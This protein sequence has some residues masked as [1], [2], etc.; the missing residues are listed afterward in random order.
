MDCVWYA[1][2][3]QAA[4]ISGTYVFCR[5]ARAAD[6]RE[7]PASAS[8]GTCSMKSL[9]A[10]DFAPGPAEATQALRGSVYVSCPQNRTLPLM[11]VQNA[12]S[13]SAD[14]TLGLYSAKFSSLDPI[15]SRKTAPITC[16]APG[17]PSYSPRMASRA[18]CRTEGSL[19][20]DEGNSLMAQV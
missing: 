9:I 6:A 10:A 19:R 8:R 1:G 13:V 15:P 4:L 11:A 12:E 2:L 20:N 16:W 17:G 3:R 5:N 18:C 14:S 7:P